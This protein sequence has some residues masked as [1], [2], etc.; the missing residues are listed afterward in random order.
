MILYHSS[1]KQFKTFQTT[2]K[3]AFGPKARHQPLFFKAT[4]EE[5]QALINAGNNIYACEVDIR[6]TFDPTK[7]YDWDA[8]PY[9]DDPEGITAVGW[10]AFYE[11]FDGEQ[12]PEDAFEK[13]WYMRTGAYDIMESSDTLD[14]LQDSGYD[15]FLLSESGKFHRDRSIGVFD[16]SLITIL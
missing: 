12:N 11:L 8:T 7:L 4:L 1:P 6:N 9:S 13:I 15:S 5:S 14:W 3:R 2:H 16:P 10:K